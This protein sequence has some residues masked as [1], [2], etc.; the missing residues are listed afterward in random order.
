LGFFFLDYYSF[1]LNP[2][3]FVLKEPLSVF[4]N[5]G[6]FVFVECME[7]CNGVLFLS[8]GHPTAP[9]ALFTAHAAC[10]IYVAIEVLSY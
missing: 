2:F 4:N 9:V 6:G 1:Q 7:R 10:N 5:I 3:H 8:L